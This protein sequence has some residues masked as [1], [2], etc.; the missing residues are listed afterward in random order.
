MSWV[1]ERTDTIDAGGNNTYNNIVV[2][3]IATEVCVV[4]V[5]FEHCY[6]QSNEWV[7]VFFLSVTGNGR[8]G[9]RDIGVKYVE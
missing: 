2:A 1:R 5:A 3:V 4:E 9:D 8:D 6:R 7:K